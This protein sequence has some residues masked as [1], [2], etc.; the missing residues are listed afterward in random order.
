MDFVSPIID[1]ISRLWDCG[2]SRTNYICD[3]KK[4]LDSLRSE[5]RK[6]RSERDYLK[7]KVE[8][9]EEKQMKRRETVETWLQMVEELEREVEVVIEEASQQLSKMCLGG[10]CPK[11]CYGSSCYKIGKRVVKKT[12]AVT[13]L[14]TEGNFIEVAD[15][16]GLAKVEEMP[17]RATVG[18]DSML[19]NVWKCLTEDDEKGII[20]IYGMEGVGKTTLL[21]KINNEF[22]HRGTHDFDLV[23]WVEVSKE[24]KVRKVQKNIGERL[25]LK[26]SEDESHDA[27]RA[28]VVFNFLNKKRFVLLLDDIWDPV[29]F[30]DV[31]IPR[32]NATNKSKVIFTT[33]FQAVSEQM[34][35]EKYFIA[36]CLGRNEAL[37]LFKKIVGNEALNSHHQIP[38][39]A[40][41]VAV[42][43]KGLP[44]ALITIGRTMAGKKDPHEW[45]DAL[46]L[47]KKSA[48]EEEEAISVGPWG[49]WGGTYWSH[50]AKGGI[51]QITIT[52]G[53]GIDSMS[54]KTTIRDCGASRAIYIRELESNLRALRSEMRALRSNRN[55]VKTK[56]EE[57]E[58]NEMRR[59]EPVATWLQMV[60]LLIES[61]EHISKTCL[62][63]CCPKTFCSSYKMGETVAIKVTAVINLR[64]EGVF[65]EVADPL[66]PAKVKKEML[67]RE[68]EGMNLI[69]SRDSVFKNLTEACELFKKTVGDVALNSRNQIPELAT[70]VA[71]KCEGLPLALVTISETMAARM[72]PHEWN[73]AVKLLRKFALVRKNLVWK[74][75]KTRQQSRW[76]NGEEGAALTG[77]TMPKGLIPINFKTHDDKGEM[78]FGDGGPNSNKIDFDWPHEYLTSIDGSYGA[79]YI[80]GNG[81]IMV[82][83]LC[84]ITNKNKYGPFCNEVGTPFTLAMKGSLLVGFHGRPGHCIDAIGIYLKPLNYLSTE[85]SSINE[86]PG[87]GIEEKLGYFESRRR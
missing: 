53:A 65:N 22:L 47:L 72:A 33:R 63:G 38:D 43:C 84:L 2:A 48:S 23:I 66:P 9:A 26:L 15:P 7:R 87:V 78:K 37:D 81:I 51:T 42:E 46:K 67:Y 62:G 25:G 71:L 20:G 11:N 40:A 61:S 44:L 36:E 4:N 76:D 5:M 16:L 52:H 14:I 13:K 31:G 82:K 35:A 86:G 50:N 60:E 57:A 64:T 83:S 59:R 56:V 39:L 3:L 73:N 32:P 85:D 18:M 17:S 10:C 58:G 1:I 79:V 69:D 8:V 55:E 49:G 45:S 24:S 75:G 54:F 74:K 30:E 34:A 21:K 28:R 80:N 27:V 12:V 77:V 68:T 70:R 41:R 29:D 6:L 19:E